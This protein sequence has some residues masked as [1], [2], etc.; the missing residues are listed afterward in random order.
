MV[1]GKGGG[2]G[3]CAGSE[4]TTTRRECKRTAAQDW[5]AVEEMLPVFGLYLPCS[6]ARRCG[7]EWL[8]EKG[9]GQAAARGAKGRPSAGHANAPPRSWYRMTCYP[10]RT[11]PAQWRGGAGE[12]G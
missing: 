7:E 2:A 10:S 1:K 5:H 8:R 11:C 12:I 6:M 9:A 3:S 4:R